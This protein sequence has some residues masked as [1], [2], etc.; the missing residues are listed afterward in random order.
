MG[1]V[2]REERELLCVW[3]REWVEHSL[4][5]GL[6]LLL[7]NPR[8]V[9]SLEQPECSCYI[10]RVGLGRSNLT[11]RSLGRRDLTNLTLRNLGRRDLTTT[12]TSTCTNS[13][14]SV[15]VAPRRRAW[16]SPNHQKH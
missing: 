11:L 5:L 2:D 4:L 15:E 10:L 13:I 8:E 7:K 1:R 16:R 3:L 6:L 12:T 9:H 14:R